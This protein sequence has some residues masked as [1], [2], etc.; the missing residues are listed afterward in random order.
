ME[1]LVQELEKRPDLKHQERGSDLNL[2]Q[3]AD[4]NELALICVAGIYLSFWIRLSAWTTIQFNC[5]IR[6]SL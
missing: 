2:N 6:I 1:K 5:R 4:P 3:V